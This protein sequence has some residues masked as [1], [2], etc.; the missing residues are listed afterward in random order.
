MTVDKVTIRQINC[1]KIMQHES[2]DLTP[3]TQTFASAI[4]AAIKFTR[5]P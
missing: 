3:H 4:A 2:L 5:F 1:S